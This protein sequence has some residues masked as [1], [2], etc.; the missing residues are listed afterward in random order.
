MK[1]LSSIFRSGLISDNPLLVLVLGLGPALAVSTTIEAAA[2]MGV[3]AAAVLIVSNTV[4]SA[5]RNAIP[6]GIR[7]PCYMALT[8]GMVTAANMLL[9]AHFPER[10]GYLGLYVPLIVANCVVLARAEIFASK[11]GVLRSAADGL[12]MG[13]GFTAAL[14]AVAAVRELLGSGSFLGYTLLPGF[15]PALIMLLPPGGLL[16]LG[17]AAAALQKMRKTR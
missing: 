11:N 4:I 6:K 1:K 10:S 7:L 9:Q 13:F 2:G 15:Q 14:V 8:A 16:V 3:V 12:A 5:L 17:F